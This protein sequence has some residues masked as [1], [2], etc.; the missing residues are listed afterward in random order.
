MKRLLILVFGVASAGIASQFPEFSQQYTQRLDGAVNEL[1]RI[2][3][4]F[5]TDAQDN[6]ITRG[7]ALSRYETSEDEFLEKRG[8]SMG[9]AIARHD[10]LKA[11]RD[12]LLESGPFERLW[13]FAR[14]Q[15]PELTQNTLDIYTPAVPVSAEGGAH[16]AAGFAGGWAILTLL[17]A[18]FGRRRKK[19]VAA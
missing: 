11:H 18:P 6:G 13:V 4:Q 1:S 3:E 12:R 10:R 5:D 15:D 14:D 16:A 8:L 17:L 19:A 9:Q 7:E 2:V